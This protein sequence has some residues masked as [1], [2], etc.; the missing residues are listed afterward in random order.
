M[1]TLNS[2]LKGKEHFNTECPIF[3]PHFQ[4]ALPGTQRPQR[5]FVSNARFEK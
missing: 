4:P 5:L 1:Q 3:S 2:P